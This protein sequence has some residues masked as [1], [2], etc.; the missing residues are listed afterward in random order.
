MSNEIRY[1]L[2]C[3]A[4]GTDDGDKTRWRL[5]FDDVPPAEIKTSQQN[6]TQ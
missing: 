5:L 4:G 6:D 3:F 2:S 1:S